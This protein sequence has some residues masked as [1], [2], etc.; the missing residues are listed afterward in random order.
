MMALEVNSSPGWLSG[1]ESACQCRRCRC[2]PWVRKIPWR[3]KWQPTLVFLPG[4]FQ[5]QRSLVGCSPWGRKELNTPERL[6][7]QH[8]Q[9]SMIS[10]KQSFSY[11]FFNFNRIF[12]SSFRFKEKSCQKYRDSNKPLPHFTYALH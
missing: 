6:N 8:T 2:D 7:M 9:R 11:C 3:R 10:R 1:E 4:K 5:G 12:L